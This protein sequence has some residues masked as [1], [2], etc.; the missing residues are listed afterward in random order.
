MTKL[1]KRYRGEDIDV[2]FEARRC[3]HVAECLRGASPADASLA[4]VY[5]TGVLPQG[6]LG[7]GYA[8]LRQ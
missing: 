5:L 2:T 3:I 1:A 8:L 4:A 6:K 7:V